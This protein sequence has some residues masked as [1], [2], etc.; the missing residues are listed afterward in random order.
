[1]HKRWANQLQQIV[2]LADREASR[3]GSFALC[4]VVKQLNIIRSLMKWNG[5]YHIQVWAS[6]TARSVINELT[7]RDRE[8][9]SDSA[10]SYFDCSRGVSCTTSALAVVTC[11]AHCLNF[12]GHADLAVE[13]AVAALCWALESESDHPCVPRSVNENVKKLFHDFHDYLW[14]GSAALLQVGLIAPVAFLMQFLLDNSELWKAT[15]DSSL[16][17]LGATG[18][19]V[20]IPLR[21]IVKYA[22]LQTDLRDLPQS[23]RC[24]QL[25][26]LSPFTSKLSRLE[27][28]LP[29]QDVG[30]LDAPKHR[31]QDGNLGSPV[32]VLRQGKRPQREWVLCSGPKRPVTTHSVISSTSN[33]VDA[34]SAF[35][36]QGIS[37]GDPFGTLTPDE[38]LCKFQWLCPAG[39]YFRTFSCPKKELLSVTKNKLITTAIEVMRNLDIPNVM[40]WLLSTGLHYINKSSKETN[41]GCLIHLIVGVVYS[42]PDQLQDSKSLVSLIVDGMKQHT[43]VL[44][45]LITGDGCGDHYQCAEAEHASLLLLSFYL[46]KDND[47]ASMVIMQQVLDSIK[48]LVQLPLNESQGHVN[49]CVLSSRLSV[50]LQTV[51]CLID[52]LLDDRH[53]E[54]C[55]LI[56][57]LKKLH[58]PA[59]VHA[60]GCISTIDLEIFLPQIDRSL[61][62]KI[63]MGLLLNVLSLSHLSPTIKAFSAERLMTTL[64]RTLPMIAGELDGGVIVE[65]LSLVDLPSL[66]SPVDL[67]RLTLSEAFITALEAQIA[68][69]GDVP[70]SL[71]AMILACARGV[72][73]EYQCQEFLSVVRRFGTQIELLLV[74]TASTLSERQLCR[75]SFCLLAQLSK[76]DTGTPVQQ[77]NIAVMAYNCLFLSVKADVWVLLR[78]IAFKNENFPSFFH[79]FSSVAVEVDRAASASIPGSSVDRILDLLQNMW[80]D[81][82]ISFHIVAEVCII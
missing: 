64:F 82:Q 26:S 81:P 66:L 59:P 39:S 55:C 37:A 2:A 60:R 71:S 49:N 80:I 36:L 11:L 77:L 63:G 74:E 48:S 19:P 62:L 54:I 46:F 78:L 31:H 8:D 6:P 15:A 38:I 47:D 56:E 50:H 20:P 5:F 32:T 10:R 41:L 75:W 12:Y 57:Q 43:G 65:L 27:T 67:L 53:F 28:L 1:M 14:G 22:A 17:S 21:L 69:S 70:A 30:A 51:G 9:L 35:Q 18:V 42:L 29:E 58:L 68:A 72:C 76:F 13:I 33:S 34:P 23:F 61:R 73:S 79:H 4:Y 52:L 25:N 3:L 40:E 24:N 16:H 44:A 7:S 45:S